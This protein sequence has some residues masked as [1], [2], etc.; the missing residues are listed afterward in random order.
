MNTFFIVFVHGSH[1]DAASGGGAEGVE[2]GTKSLLL[3]CSVR[4]CVYVMEGR[5]DLCVC[6]RHVLLSVE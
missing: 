6:F 5:K 1:D 4:V 3:V 2:Y